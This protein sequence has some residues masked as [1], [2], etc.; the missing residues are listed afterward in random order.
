MSG[1]HSLSTSQMI[2]QPSIDTRLLERAVFGIVHGD[3]QA[4]TVSMGIRQP[5]L[6][7]LLGSTG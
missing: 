6:G 4:G 1:R 2:L 7:G 5:L 3:Y